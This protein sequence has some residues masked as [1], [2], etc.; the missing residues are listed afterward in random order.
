MSE[1]LLSLKLIILAIVA[2]LMIGGAL[3]VATPSDSGA[4]TTETTAVPTIGGGKFN[5]GKP[6][7]EWPRK[8]QRKYKAAK[9]QMEFCRWKPAWDRLYP[10][11]KGLFKYRGY[12]GYRDLAVAAYSYGI[13]RFYRKT[14]PDRRWRSWLKIAKKVAFAGLKV[15]PW[16]G[17]TDDVLDLVNVSRWEYSVNEGSSC[18]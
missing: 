10:M 2:G 8:F 1:K 12:H 13:V 4:S 3:L 11:R 6:K 9:R 17:G 7:A 15:S 18:H 5:P 14:P 16:F